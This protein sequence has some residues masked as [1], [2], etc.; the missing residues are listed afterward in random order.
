[1]NDVTAYFEPHIKI[2]SWNPYLEN[3]MRNKHF[4]DYSK[5]IVKTCN[6]KYVIHLNKN[7]MSE[8]QNQEN[9]SLDLIHYFEINK[10]KIILKVEV[11]IN[12][13]NN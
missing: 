5:F 4:E 13:I 11:F 12:N 7:V 9:I 8:Q 6:L 10:Y 1:M 2:E 3:G